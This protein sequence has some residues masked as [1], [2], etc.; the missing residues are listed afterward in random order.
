ML[1]ISS[2]SENKERHKD[3]PLFDTE[4]GLHIY[5]EEWL[6]LGSVEIQ[7]GQAPAELKPVQSRLYSVDEARAADSP[8]MQEV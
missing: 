6:I 3:Y 4:E 8:V 2:Q 7:P 5:E 1:V